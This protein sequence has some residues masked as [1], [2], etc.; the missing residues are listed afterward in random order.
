MKKLSL[1]LGFTLIAFLASAQNNAN[2]EKKGEHHR[3]SLTWAQR[4]LHQGNFMTMAQPILK[5]DSWKIKENKA[6]GS[7]FGLDLCPGYFPINRLAIGPELSFNY[8]KYETPSTSTNSSTITKSSSS[9]YGLWGR[10]YPVLGGFNDMITPVQPFIGADLTFGSSKNSYS[11]SMYNSETNY[12]QTHWEAYFGADLPLC[13][14]CAA[15]SYYLGYQYTKETNKDNS[16]DVQTKTGF[17]TGLALDLYFKGH[18]S[19]CDG[20]GSKP[21]LFK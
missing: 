5:F 9:E 6:T 16:N 15:L 1:L 7:D 3:D 19:C 13:C 17:Y 2:T 8:S 20:P 14:H 4:Y 11:S 12:K 21:T 18:N 10:G